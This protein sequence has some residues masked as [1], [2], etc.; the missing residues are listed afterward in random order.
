MN[1]GPPESLANSQVANFNKCFP[2]GIL[3]NLRNRLPMGN[4]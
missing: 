4:V 3:E 2:I 1:W